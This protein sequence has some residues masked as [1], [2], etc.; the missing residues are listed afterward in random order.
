MASGCVANADPGGPPVP[1]HVDGNGTAAQ[2]FRDAI[3]DRVLDQRLQHQ[4]GHPDV[5]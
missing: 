5:G 3:F 4:S 1:F 2:P